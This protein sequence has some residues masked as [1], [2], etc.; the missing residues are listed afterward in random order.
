[1]RPWAA[2]EGLEVGSFTREGLEDFDAELRGYRH[3]LRLPHWVLLLL[4]PIHLL[5]AGTTINSLLIA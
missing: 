3:I 1:M 4:V 2:R 5:L